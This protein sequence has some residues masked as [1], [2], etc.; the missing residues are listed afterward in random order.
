MAE[1]AVQH[2]ASLTPEVVKTKLNVALTRV[3]FTITGLNDME[4]KLVYNE[5]NLAEIKAFIE[6]NKKAIDAVEAERVV[7]KEK[8][9][10][11]GKII[12]AEAKA[13]QTQ[14]NEPLARASKKYTEICKEVDKRIAEEKAENERKERIRQTINRDILQYTQSIANANNSE[15]LNKIQASINLAKG[16][17]QGAARY[18]EF[19]SEMIEK[20]EG[21]NDSIKKQ[22][23]LIKGLEDLKKKQTTTKDEYAKEELDIKIQEAEASIEEAKVVVQEEAISQATESTPTSY[24]VVHPTVRARRTTWKYEVTD[25]NLLQK[26]MPHLVKLVADEEKIDDLLK[27][28]KSDGSLDN[29]EEVTINGIRFYKEKLY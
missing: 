19:H 29:Q 5:D 6:K 20:L 3:Q 12:D 18:M 28:K 27:T 8:P 15:D 13:L 2:N 16:A 4:R 14:L 17:K 1:Q 11:E 23:D 21:L 10:R 24:S 22:K 25:I 9:L 7:L 26:K